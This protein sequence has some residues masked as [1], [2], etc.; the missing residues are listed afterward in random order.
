MSNEALPKEILQLI[1]PQ[2][3]RSYA[4]AKGW[5]RVPGVNGKIALFSHPQGQWDQLLVPMDESLDDYAKRLRDVVEN[6]AEFESL[7]V[8]EVLNDLMAW[9]ADTLRYRVASSA[10][11]RGSIPLMEGIQLLEGAKRSILAAACSVLNPVTHHPRMSRSEAQQLLH[12][13]HLGQTE[14]GSYS[15]SLSCPL[16]A[17]E[18]DQALLPGNEPFTR[19]A[20]AMLMRS[21]SRMIVAI[22][23]DTI[24]DVFKTVPEEPVISANLCEALLQMQPE[25]E[26]S[27][28][29]VKASWATTLPP[30]NPIPSMVRIKR[31]Y[32]PI[33]EDV[34]KKLLPAQAPAAALFVGYIVSLGGEPGEDGRM[35][36]EATLA[37]M[38]EE[39]I[40]LVRVDLS[41]D[42]WHVAH[43]ALGAHGIV[44][45]KGILHRGT[46]VHRITDII[47]FAQVQ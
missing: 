21:L 47:E 7:P 15:V 33:I 31:E 2:Q 26:N 25:D 44:R 24:P 37:V 14:R 16:R 20:V 32:F 3:V 36:G 22:E 43:A 1:K 19:R 39:Q 18:Q 38:H 6:L 17:V 5:Q 34:S 41:S 8:V 46:R 12:A 28:L 4:L 35:Q 30:Q 11:G 9:D 13:C 42:N 27:H 10:T 23:A 40:Q 29:D 45:I